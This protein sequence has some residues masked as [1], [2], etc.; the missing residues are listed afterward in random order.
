MR[1]SKYILYIVEGGYWAHVAF[2]RGGMTQMARGDPFTHS[3]PSSC[4]VSTQLSLEIL[5]SDMVHSSLKPLPL[6]GEY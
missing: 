2:L 1:L 6:V 3:T 5:K 4:V